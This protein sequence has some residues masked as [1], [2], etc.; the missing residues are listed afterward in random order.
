MVFVIMFDTQMKKVFGS[1]DNYLWGFVNHKPIET[2]YKWSNKIPVKTSKSESI[3]KDMV[4]RGFRLVGPTV[5][6]SF[7]QAAGLTNDHLITCPRHSQCG[8]TLRNR[9]SAILPSHHHLTTTTTL[10]NA[11]LLPSLIIATE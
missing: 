4:K 7:M 3:S 8:L 1:F 9:N 2:R 11:P 6:H 5:I 10:P